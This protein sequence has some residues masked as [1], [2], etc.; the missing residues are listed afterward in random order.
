MVGLTDWEAAE[1]LNTPDAGLAL[2]RVNV[3]TSEVRELML[4]NGSFAAIKLASEN[5]ALPDVLR[6]ACI[7]AI[8]T[9]L[10]TDLIEATKPS[11]Y[12]NTTALLTALVS[13]GVIVQGV[14]DA[15]LAL[16]DRPQSWAEANDFPNGVT[17]RDVGL[18]RGGI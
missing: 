17:A 2:K 5:T 8:T 15:C 4:A 3:P 14:A 1:A 7:T 11:V 18:A 13:A 16:A 10:H 9:I 12:A 6:G